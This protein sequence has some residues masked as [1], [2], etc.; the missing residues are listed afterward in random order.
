MFRLR[1]YK[2]LPDRVADL[3][4]WAGL[5]TSGQVLTKTGELMAVLRFRGPDLESAGKIEQLGVALRLNNALKRLVGGWTVQTEA[6][7]RETTDYP[8]SPWRHPVAQLLDAERQAQFQDAGRHFETDYYVTLIYKTPTERRQRAV[9]WL[10]EHVPADHVHYGQVR[11][12]MDDVVQGLQRLLGDVFPYVERLHGSALLTYLHAAATLREHPV[13]VPEV[14]MYLDVLLGTA[15][16]LPGIRPYLGP[17]ALRV[18][19]LRSLPTHTWPGVL[20]GLDT[21]EFPSRVVQRWIALDQAHALR[22]IRKYERRRLAKRKGL[23]TLLREEILKTPS[24]MSDPDAEDKAADARAAQGLVAGNDVACGYYTASVVVWHADPAVAA[25]RLAQVE[26]VLQGT[27]CTTHDEDLNAVEAWLGTMPGHVH[28][29][30]RRPLVHSMHLA[31]LLPC[32][33]VW[34]G[35]P[36]NAHLGGPPLMVVS[37]AGGTPFRL[38]LHQGDVGD[39]LIIGPKGSGKSTLLSLL[40]L[41]WQ[42]YPGAQTFLFDKG[43]SARVATA[44]MGG[45]WYGLG[46]QDDLALQPLAQIDDPH[47]CAWAMAWVADLLTQEGLTLTPGLKT[48]VWG[49]LCSLAQAAAPLRT[50]TG[51]AALVQHADCR[52]ALRPYTLQGPHGVLLDADHDSLSAGAWQCF[53]TGALLDTPSAVAPVLFY[54]FHRLEQWLTGAPTLIILDEAWIFLDTPLFANRIRLWL[55]TLRK[56][57][58]SVIFASQN[59]ADVAKSSI[60]A[61]LGQECQTRIFLPNP[62]ALEPQMAG[63][64]AAFGLT[65]RQMEV[66]AFGSP[67]R[68][69]YYQSAAGNRLFELE[70]GPV[71]L[72]LA[73]A[74]SPADLAQIAAITQERPDNVAGRWFA[75]RG[76][77]WAAT[78]VWQDNPAAAEEYNH[79]TAQEYNHDTAQGAS[80]RGD[81]EERAG[82]TG[83]ADEYAA[84]VGVSGLGGVWRG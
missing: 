80:A 49:A 29:N 14:P 31:H 61:T 16:L 8:V 1:E 2:A 34:A 17:Q 45:R 62:R 69:Y 82:D 25:D 81:Q 70:L 35:P 51:L 40:A 63:Y 43:G 39:T 48:E 30:I 24:A 13:A 19:T 76:L 50:M 84:A 28:A 26:R 37:S 36:G 72:A 15:D 83:G 11:D 74:G 47:E 65:P 41:Q 12:Y 71:A 67:K 27:G 18:L 57:N 75:S 33:A 46:S 9:Q 20:A 60:A 59:L 53:E 64:Y 3:L 32:H 58:A 42:R 56:L 55:K 44:C 77:E 22:E 78:I 68:H 4:P 52:E 7:R 5:L 21:L 6:W 38:S 23:L 79:D 66:I 54:L 10:W 73:G